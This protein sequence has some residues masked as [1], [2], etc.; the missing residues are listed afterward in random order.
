[1]AVQLIVNV[2]ED[3][4]SGAIVEDGILQ[5]LF[6]E[7]YKSISGNIYVG[8][9][10]KI[11]HGLNAAFVNIGESRNAFLKL[12]DVSKSYISQVLGG[13][14]IKEGSKIL[15][16]VKN[17]NIGNK[18]PLVTTKV[19]L[20]GRFVVYFPFSKT[21]GVSKKI[22]SSPERER[23]KKIMKNIGKTEGLIIRTA[24]EYVSD[25]LIIEEISALK[26]KWSE[27]LN[28]FKRSRKPKL[29]VM[30][31][32]EADLI[33]RERLNKA[34]DEIVVNSQEMYN[35]FRDAC[36]HLAK[37][38]LIHLDEG[39]VFE[40]F[41]IYSHINQALERRVNLPS[42]GY[43]AIDTTEALTVFD[44]N[45]ASFVQERDHGEL[46]HKINIEAA[47]EI[48]RQLRLRNIGGMIVVDFIDVPSKDYRDRL[49][50]EL[51]EAVKKD[52]AR[53][54]LV[55]FTKLGLFEMTRKRKQ[56]P[57]DQVFFSA[58]P[59]CKGSGRVI[60]PS[61]VIKRLLDELSSL[62]HEGF[63][64]IRISLHQRFSGYH[65]GIKEKLPAELRKKVVFSFDYQ[66]P[67]E[68]SITLVKK[69]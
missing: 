24:A 51:E 27:I 66:N 2:I 8:R 64:T 6:I 7:E 65:E 53:V 47:R 59:T 23:L 67:G 52:S 61:L 43:I 41:G 28:L 22:S 56:I 35:K 46:A 45:S 36:K 39:D 50:K 32:S 42:G 26:E 11:I 19:S 62:K 20:A 5:E 29:L 30:E 63:S 21:K 12:I 55:G 1:M 3:K 69:S 16:Q 68:Y 38:P 13:N 40:K 58:C 14:Q 18:G 15:V 17:D 9:V 33:I 25:E 10:E 34:I 37:K 60:S 44:V 4:V 31:P 49:I 54:E 57:L 48:A